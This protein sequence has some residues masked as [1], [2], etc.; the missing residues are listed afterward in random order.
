MLYL[1]AP[2]ILRQLSLCQHKSR[3]CCRAE[4]GD[5]ITNIKA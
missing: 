5:A 1:L 4:I 3:L 2:A